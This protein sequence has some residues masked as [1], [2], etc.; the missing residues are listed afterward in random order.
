MIYADPLIDMTVV[1]WGQRYETLLCL[2]PRL[3]KP[4]AP[5]RKTVWFYDV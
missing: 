4:G 2:N 5:H 1:L 3:N